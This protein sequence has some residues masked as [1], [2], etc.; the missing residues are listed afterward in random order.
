MKILFELEHLLYM[1][2]LAGLSYL[3]GNLVLGVWLGAVF[4][5]GREH[6]QAEY[7]WIET[8][9]LGKRANMPWWATLDK[10][11][12]DFHSWFWNLTMP[13]VVAIA[14]SIWQITRNN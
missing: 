1:L 6:A 14:V 11:V 4:F 13:I 5:T 7:R 3:L 9:G 12:W 8:F 10:R 2:L